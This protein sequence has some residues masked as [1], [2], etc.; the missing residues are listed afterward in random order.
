MQN[1]VLGAFAYKITGSP[2][3]VSLIIFAQLVPLL[4]L[5][6]SG[7]TWPTSSTAEA[8][9]PRQHRAD[10]FALAIAWIAHFPDPSKLGLF[11]CTLAIGI[12]QAVYAPTFGS[13]VPQLVDKED[14]A[15]AVSL[16]SVNMNL[17]RV[18]GPV[19]GSVVYAE[20]GISWVFIGNAM[21]YLFIIGA[22]LSVQLPRVHDPTH[23][24]ARAA[25]RVQA[26][27]G[28]GSAGA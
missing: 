25:R 8:A 15:G 2:T 20:F 17:S 26:A 28:P 7:G 21:S 11:L 23:R 13:L 16:N 4:L 14:L 6:R 10:L 22:L 27:R 12:G 5:P 24:R 19:I 9:H 3:F 18:I 1:V